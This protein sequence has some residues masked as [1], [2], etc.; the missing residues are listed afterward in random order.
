PTPSMSAVSP[1]STTSTPRPTAPHSFSTPSSPGP[2]ICQTP[3]AVT[4]YRLGVVGHDVVDAGVEA[5]GRG[6]IAAGGVGPMVVVV[7]VPDS[8]RVSSLVLG[9]V[10]A[11]VEAFVGHQLLVALDLPV[12]SGCVGPGALV[13]GDERA[14]RATE[15]LRRVVAAVVGDQTGDPR[16]ACSAK[17]TIARWKNAMV[18]AAVSSS[19]ASV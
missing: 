19:S 3:Q 6:L 7:V 15:R 18:V 1:P 5:C 9:V 13:P 17:N 11:G 4:S 8:N 14:G 10:G 12:M 16:D 2:R